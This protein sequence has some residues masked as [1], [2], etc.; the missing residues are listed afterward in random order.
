MRCLLGLVSV[1]VMV[2]TLVARLVA[3]VL[4]T[5]SRGLTV[6][7]GVSGCMAVVSVH[8]DDFGIIITRCY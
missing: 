5:R 2:A 7:G 1:G 6:M 8:G 4:V 3:G